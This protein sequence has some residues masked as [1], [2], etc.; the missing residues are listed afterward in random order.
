[1]LTSVNDLTTQLIV[2]GSYSVTLISLS[3][4]IIS[5]G[6]ELH[7]SMPVERIRFILLPL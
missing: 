6:T 7:E 3:G 2:N 1:M 4:I 5:G